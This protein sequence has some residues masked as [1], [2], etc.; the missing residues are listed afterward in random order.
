MALDSSV[1]GLRAANRP[2]SA[3]S[4]T[5]QVRQTGSAACREKIIKQ[6]FSLT[7]RVNIFKMKMSFDS[8]LLKGSVTRN[9][10]S[11]DRDLER[12]NGV[13]LKD[14]LNT[15]ARPLSG[16]ITLAGLSLFLI[17]GH[18]FQRWT[19]S[20]AKEILPSRWG[21]GRIFFLYFLRKR[22]FTAYR[23]FWGGSFFDLNHKKSFKIK[24]NTVKE[25]CLK[26]K[27]LWSNLNFCPA[28][29]FCITQSFRA[30]CSLFD[31]GMN[32][33]LQQVF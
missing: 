29:Q 4:P 24:G 18:Y 10:F 5:L 15:F 27:S 23:P 25:Y 14:L 3:S 26:K 32:P 8:W 11:W 17:G 2:L 31:H 33:N 6:T 19:D 20:F 21:M 9:P 7:R 22:L 13:K 16:M 30:S 1:G 12:Q 28:F